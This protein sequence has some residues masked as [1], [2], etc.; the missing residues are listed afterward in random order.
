S[1][2]VATEGKNGQEMVP[3]LCSLQG[4]AGELCPRQAGHVEDIR[5]QLT[6]G[7]EARGAF[8]SRQQVLRNVVESPEVCVKWGPNGGERLALR[9]EHGEGWVHDI[10]G[11]GFPVVGQRHPELCVPVYDGGERPDLGDVGFS[12]ASPQ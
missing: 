1:L 3:A 6:L 7:E 12:P 11:R 8:V 2:E 10:P 9:V 4:E 5:R